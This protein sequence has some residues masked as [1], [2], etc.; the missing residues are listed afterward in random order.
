MITEQRK[1]EIRDLYC[2]VAE[3]RYVLAKLSDEEYKE[4]GLGVEKDTLIQCFSI[5][6]GEKPLRKDIVDMRKFE[7]VIRKKEEEMMRQ[8]G[9]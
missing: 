1:E 2:Q 8:K 5:F 9:N 6:L 3:M 4:L 7:I